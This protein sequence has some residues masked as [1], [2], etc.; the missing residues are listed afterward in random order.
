MDTEVSSA[1]LGASVAVRG[2]AL[3]RRALTAARIPG[4]GAKLTSLRCPTRLPAGAD[5]AK[6]CAK[7]LHEHIRSVVA[8]S[9]SP[10]GMPRPDALP[11][12]GPAGAAPAGTA[13]A[14]EPEAG[15]GPGAVAEAAQASTWPAQVRWLR[16]SHACAGL[17]A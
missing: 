12:A 16:N 5:V 11:D 4:T 3:T 14:A 17:P 1:P 6:H 7:S 9:V 13:P 15:A 2:R 10:N 8:A